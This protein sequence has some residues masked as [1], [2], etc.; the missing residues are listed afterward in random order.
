MLNTF[1]S[2]LDFQSL[3][4][5]SYRDQKTSCVGLVIER[6]K[7]L[8]LVYR[9]RYTYRRSLQKKKKQT[10][11][12][13]CFFRVL[14]WL[15]ILL[16]IIITTYLLIF[17]VQG[18]LK[19]DFLPFSCPGCLKPIRI[20]QECSIEYLLSLSEMFFVAFFDSFFFNVFQRL[21]IL[22]FVFF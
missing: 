9:L 13:A 2:S 20:L 16:V 12:L 1:I 10:V 15:I 19:G 5:F 11:F 21:N 4:I 3:D 14:M 18:V 7:R 22:S 6:R 8:S 17:F